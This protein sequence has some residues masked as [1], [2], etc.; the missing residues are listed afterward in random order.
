MGFCIWEAYNYVGKKSYQLLLPWLPHTSYP[1]KLTGTLP[2]SEFL[3]YQ[4]NGTHH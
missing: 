4:V 1:T 2:S 3:F